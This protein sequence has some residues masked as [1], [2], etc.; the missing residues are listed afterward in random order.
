MEW[1]GSSGLGPVGAVALS[2]MVEGGKK[3]GKMVN[4]I[5][6]HWLHYT[7]FYQWEMNEWEHK[8]GLEQY[9]EN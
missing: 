6:Y 2:V 5:T 1:E 3:E 9:T 4:D 8:C 7:V